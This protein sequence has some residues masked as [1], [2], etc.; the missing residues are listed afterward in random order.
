MPAIG[1]ERLQAAIGGERL[2]LLQAGVS[3]SRSPRGRASVRRLSVS[4]AGRAIATLSLSSS[5]TSTEQPTE[6]SERKAAELRLADDARAAV[7]AILA[8][9]DDASSSLVALNGVLT[10]M[11]EGCSSSAAKAGDNARSRAVARPS[12]APPTAASKRAELRTFSDAVDDDLV[13]PILK[14]LETHG[15][16]VSRVGSMFSSYLM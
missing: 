9:C 1:G 5:G 4:G 7:D 13:E 2:G 16:L 6:A 14:W 12:G 11:L 3:A 10:R 15:P 8:T